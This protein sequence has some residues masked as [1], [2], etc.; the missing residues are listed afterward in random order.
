MVL[1]FASFDD[2]VDDVVAAVHQVVIVEM[3]AEHVRLSHQM[4]AVKFKRPCLKQ[5]RRLESGTCS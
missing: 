2:F 1:E 4:E 3:V 5:Q